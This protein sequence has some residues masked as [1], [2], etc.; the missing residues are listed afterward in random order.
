MCQAVSTVALV[1][2]DF[3]PHEGLTCGTIYAS[4]SCPCE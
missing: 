1:G 3:P 4:I 2:R